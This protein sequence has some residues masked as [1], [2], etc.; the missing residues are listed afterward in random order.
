MLVLAEWACLLD[1]DQV[2]L[3]RDLSLIVGEVGLPLPDILRGEEMA[4]NRRLTAS[5][6]SP[7]PS[8]K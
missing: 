8:E 4:D 6:L 1:E 5:N 7:R 2:T 3:L